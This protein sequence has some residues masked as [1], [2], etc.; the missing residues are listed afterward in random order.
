[1]SYYYLVSSLPSISLDAKPALSLDAFRSS[2]ADHLSE[3]DAYALN[4]LLNIDGVPV[5]HTFV[6]N[7]IARETQ[8]RNASA[9]L[10]AAKLQK[11]AVDFVREHSG[12]DV[13]IEDSVEEAF[14]H[15]NPMKRERALDKIRWTTLDE[16][17]GADPFSVN[18]VLAYAI[19]LRLAERW[20][21]MD[22]EQG[23][24]KIEEAISASNDVDK[25]NESKNITK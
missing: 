19:K 22:P 16:L 1:M 8:L 11:D 7:W 24:T 5:D 12:F 20:A 23:Q 18:I 10:R 9:R 15:S 13:G 25:N 17:A 2:C 4:S 3:H 21:A 14:N 6:N